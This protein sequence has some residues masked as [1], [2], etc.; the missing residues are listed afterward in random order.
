[1][2]HEGMKKLHLHRKSLDNLPFKILLNSPEYFK[3]S[4]IT[5]KFTVN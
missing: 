3:K 5:S 1:M 2:T 4:I